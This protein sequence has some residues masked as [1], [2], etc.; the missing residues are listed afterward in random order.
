MQSRV[1]LLGSTALAAAALVMGPA[2][3]SADQALE[4]RIKALEKAGGMY[5]TKSKKTMKNSPVL[6]QRFYR[7]EK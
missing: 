2:T 6:A 3:A 1:K 4:K 5:V 7:E